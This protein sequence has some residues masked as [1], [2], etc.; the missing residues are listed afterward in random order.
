[1]AEW[2]YPGFEANGWFGFFLPA[3]APQPI[4]DK[5]GAELAAIVKQP[6]VSKRLSEMGLIPVGSTPQQ[7]R[8]VLDT[9]AAHWKH[10]V[11]AAQIRMD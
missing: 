11:D 9:D 5:L 1:M 3:T 6:D 4:V 2:G 7:F 8:A 10:I